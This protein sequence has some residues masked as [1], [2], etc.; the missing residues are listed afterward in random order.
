MAAV[1]QGY[2][3]GDSGAALLGPV[4]QGAVLPVVE[5]NVHVGAGQTVAEGVQV[6]LDVQGHRHAAGAHDAQEG[7][8]IVVAAAAH[9][10]HMEPASRLPALLR[11]PGGDGHAVGGKLFIGDVID[12][13]IFFIAEKYMIFEFISG[14]LHQIVNGLRVLTC[15]HIFV[16]LKV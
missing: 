5:E 15:D 4:H 8:Q 11:H 10:A 13:V 14:V 12:H 7:G 6:H 16:P 1:L 2:I 9:E 3:V